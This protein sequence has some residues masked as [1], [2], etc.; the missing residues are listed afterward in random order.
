MT[1]KTHNKMASEKIK[2]KGWLVAFA[3]LSINLALGI[4]YSWSI[5][6]DTIQRSIEKGGEGAFSWHEASL[7]DPPRYAFWRLPFR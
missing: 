2:N 4:L 3:G 6:K 5:F 1:F 7:N